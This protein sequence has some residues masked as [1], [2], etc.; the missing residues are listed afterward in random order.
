M[1]R[2]HSNHVFLNNLDAK[3]NQI[4]QTIVIIWCY[5]L[6]QNK[7]EQLTPF[8]PPKQW[9]RREGA[10][11]R[12][13]GI[14]EMGGGGVV[15]MFHL[16]YPR[17]NLG[18]NKKEQLTPFP[19]SKQWWRRKGAKTCHFGIIEMGGRGSPDVLSILSKIV[20][21]LP[22][23]LWMQQNRPIWLPVL[24]YYYPYHSLFS[25]GFYHKTSLWQKRWHSQITAVFRLQASQPVTT[26]LLSGYRTYK[27]D[28]LFS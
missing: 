4:Y 23:G 8:P 1:Y 14:I 18:Q 19:H 25:I 20:E 3:S 21:S 7:K 27:P 2:L 22:L 9:W 11:T 16:F 15:Q 26:T 6:G 12:H 13:F 5:N 28:L 10:K 17:L 24:E